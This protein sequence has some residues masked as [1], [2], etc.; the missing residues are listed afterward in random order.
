MKIVYTHQC[1]TMQGHCGLVTSNKTIYIFFKVT[2]LTNIYTPQNVPTIYDK[3]NT[4]Q[5]NQ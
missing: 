4:R 1:L 2:W 3:G 5:K